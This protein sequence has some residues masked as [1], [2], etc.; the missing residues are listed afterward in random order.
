VVIVGILALVTATSL[1]ATRDDRRGEKHPEHQTGHVSHPGGIPG[2]L[3]ADTDTDASR[4]G[5]GS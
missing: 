2:S 3:R 4:R 5:P 1:Y